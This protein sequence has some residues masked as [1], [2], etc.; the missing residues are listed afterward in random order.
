M[1]GAGTSITAGN[2][3]GLNDG[4]CALLLASDEAV[5]ALGPDAARPR[6]RHGCGRRA[7]AHDGHRAGAGDRQA[8]GTAAVSSLNDFDTIEIN[9][10]FAAQVLAVTRAL[11]LAD[12]AAHVNANG[13]AIALG[14]PLGAS[15]ARL[16][17]TAMRELRATGGA[18]RWCRC[19]SAWAGRRRW[20]WSASDEPPISST[21]QA[22][23]A[24]ATCQIRVD[25]VATIGIVAVEMPVGDCR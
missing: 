20:R 24:I 1:L 9:E 2:A 16:A 7:A 23:L 4:A 8:A 22:I 25:S 6:A 14:H 3:S 12:D 15:G 11:G 5:D 19:A 21:S 10:A 13:G 17:L 18:A